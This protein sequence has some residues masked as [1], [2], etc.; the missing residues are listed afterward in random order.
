M[1]FKLTT[2]DRDALR[3]LQRN[4]SDRSASVNVTTLILLDKGLDISDYLS[5]DDSTIYRYISSF[6]KD[7]LASYLETDYQGYWG[8]LSSSQITELR[9]ELKTNL[10]T[11]SKQVAERVETSWQIN[12]TA[13]GVVN[14]LNRIGFTYKQTKC[15]HCEADAEK[16]QA[17]IE[18]LNHLLN[19]TID[20]ESVMNFADGVHPTHTARSTHTWIEKGIERQ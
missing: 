5:I 4:I 19:P 12:Y 13:S 16:Q 7:S 11:D 17:F 10:Y 20:N 9:Q 1:N 6:Q 18:E 15:V 8:R 14:L 3:K 2:S